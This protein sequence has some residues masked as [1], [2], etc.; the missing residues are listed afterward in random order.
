MVTETCTEHGEPPCGHSL[1]YDVKKG[2]VVV[3]PIFPGE[4][5]KIPEKPIP[6]WKLCLIIF[7]VAVIGSLIGSF[8]ADYL[9]R[10]L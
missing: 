6:P 7:L 3:R 1:E 10:Y 2:E 5:F 9:R 4:I 8:L